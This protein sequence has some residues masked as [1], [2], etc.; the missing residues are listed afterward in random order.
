MKPIHEFISVDSLMAVYVT[1]HMGESGLNINTGFP[2]CL[3]HQSSAVLRLC[4]GVNGPMSALHLH[5]PGTLFSS[6]V[7][8]A[9]QQLMCTFFYLIYC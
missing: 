7:Q 1:Q 3:L 6:P 5:S 9:Q 4:S 2:L 8:R